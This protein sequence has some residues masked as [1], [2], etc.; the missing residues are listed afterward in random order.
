MNNI[1]LKSC[2]IYIFCIDRKIKYIIFIFIFI[3]ILYIMKCYIWNKISFIIFN[4]KFF[5]YYLS[6]FKI[7]YV[8]SSLRLYLLCS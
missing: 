6:K 7:I 2:I 4:I 8:I 3:K 5:T 1:Y